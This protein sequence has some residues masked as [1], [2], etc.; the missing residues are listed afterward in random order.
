MCY[1]EDGLVTCVHCL[2]NL[3]YQGKQ[4]IGINKNELIEIF[5]NPDEI[6]DPIWLG[7]DDEQITFEYDKNSL[8][9]WLDENNIVVSIFCS[10]NED[11]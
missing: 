2:S 10:N 5:G 7:D 6:G 8:Q 9:V 4:L 1:V 11:D 3:V